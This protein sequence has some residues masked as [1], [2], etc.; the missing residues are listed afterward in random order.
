MHPDKPSHQRNILLFSGWQTINIG[1]IGHTP[2][3]LRF[4]EEQIPEAHLAVA[5]QATNPQVTEMLRLRFPRV[6]WVDGTLDPLGVATNNELQ[7]VFDSADLVIQNSGMLYNRFWPNDGEVLQACVHR[8]KP[9]GIY[10]QSFDGFH[11]DKQ[12]QLVWLL[13]KASFVFCRDSL[14]LDYLKSVGVRN[15]KLSWGPDGCFGIDVRDDATADQFLRESGLATGAFVAV[16]LRTNTPKSKHAGALNPVHPTPE[17]QTTDK[18]WAAA[19][20]QVMEWILENTDASILLAPEV[21]KEVLHAKRLLWEP[22]AQKWPDR[23]VHRD[24]FWNAD[25]AFSVYSRARYL[26]AMEPHSCIMALAAG[27]PA[28]HYYSKTH[29]NKA[30][31]FA[32]IGLADWLIDIDNQPVKAVIDQLSLWSL[33]ETSA[34]TKARLGMNQV[35]RR[36]KERACD[37]RQALNLP[38]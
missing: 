6:T 33:D 22:L 10:G 29:G 16:V 26:V 9:F 12:Q 1:D 36:A 18:R 31:M 35:E 27:I 8:K 14:S 2:G 24:G 30:Q 21:D 11:T 34:R 38:A 3:T 25:E 4:L 37:L 15:E 23:I 20:C 19:L 28:L 13:N 7:A 32:D 5:L 17:Q